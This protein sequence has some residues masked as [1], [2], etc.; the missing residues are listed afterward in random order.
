VDRH[1]SSEGSN[2][3]DRLLQLSQSALAR[4]VI[5]SVGLPLPERLARTAEP[6]SER[7]LDN[8]R[9]TVGGGGSLGDALA[10]ALARDGA[11]VSLVEVAPPPFLAAAEAWG[12]P[13]GTGERPHALVF[14]ATGIDRVDGLDGLFTFFQPR[15]RSL[16]RSGRVL[17]LGR[18]EGADPEAAAAQRAL[19]GFVRSVGREIGRR[20]ATASLVTVAEGAEDRLAGVLRFLLSPRSAYVSGQV[21]RVTKT[22]KAREIPRV[23]PLEGQVVLVTGAA[24]GIGAATA[25][26]L[27]RE[28]AR[29]VVLDRPAVDGPAS[30]VAAE[31]N[32]RVILADLAEPGAAAEVAAALDEVH[33][34]VHNAG[35]TRDKTLGNMDAARWDAC[36]DVNLA[37]V[38]RLTEAL[39][40][41]MPSHGRIVCLSS[42]AGIAGNAGQVNYAASKAG[43]IGYVE[44]LGARL[45]RRGIAVNAVAPGFIETRLTDAIPVATREV[46]RRL[47]NLGQGGLPEDVAQVIT[48]LASPAGS[49]LCGQ[50]L[51]VCGGNFVGA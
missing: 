43:I 2:V 4:R 3:P 22:V 51:R 1:F 30:E 18:P 32:G 25:R 17:V 36:L 9:I 8:Q 41:K 35:V 10:G 48:W 19:E 6:W 16:A 39:L 33:V 37:G 46:A 27:A 31:V 7:E 47:S 11:E 20:G 49:A 50:T 38:I 14:D 15:I 23:R 13:L 44:A 42:I 28:G 12:R 24:R 5:G 21:V 29:V 40:P 34:I 45:A 26:A